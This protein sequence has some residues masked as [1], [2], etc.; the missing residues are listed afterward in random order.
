MTARE[1]DSYGV[2]FDTPQE[3]GA[4]DF[5]ALDTQESRVVRRDLL[6][7]PQPAPV[8]GGETREIREGD[9]LMFGRD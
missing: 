5:I 1:L 9:D 3:S 7:P 6:A 8:V 4:N 2:V